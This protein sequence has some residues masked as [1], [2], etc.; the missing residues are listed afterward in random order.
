MSQAYK[1]GDI[2]HVALSG[3]IDGQTKLRPALFW[4]EDANDPNRILVSGIFGTA[5]QRRWE[6][7]LSP[8]QY[9]GLAKECFIRID[10]TQYIDINSVI[11]ILGSLDPIAFALIKERMQAYSSEQKM[12]SPKDFDEDP[13]SIF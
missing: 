10:E 2:L 3:R 1:A 5:T 7:R 4:L 11:K 8:N 9:N 13:F 6:C 12:S